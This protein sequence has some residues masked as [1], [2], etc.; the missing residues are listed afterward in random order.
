[1]ALG[2]HMMMLWLKDYSCLPNNRTASNKRT[3]WKYCY[4]AALKVCKKHDFFNIK[5]ILRLEKLHFFRNFHI[6][7]KKIKVTA[8][9]LGHTAW[10]F[11][12]IK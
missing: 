11:F 2:A 4:A 9:L 7:P 3:A 12:Q 8:S 6:F 10:K 5:G 1:M